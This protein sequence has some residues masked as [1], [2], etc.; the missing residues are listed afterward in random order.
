MNKSSSS[1]FFTIVLFQRSIFISVMEMVIDNG[2]WSEVRHQLGWIEWLFNSVESHCRN[3]KSITEFE[4]LLLLE[5]LVGTWLIGTKRLRL[6]ESAMII[7]SSLIDKWWRNKGSHKLSWMLKSLVITNRLQMLISVSLRYFIAEWEELEY[8]F[9]IQK[10]LLL[11]KKEARRISLWSIMSLRKE[12]W[13][14]ASLMLMKMATL[15]YSFVVSGSLA[16]VSQLE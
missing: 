9:M 16:N 8:T 3:I 11:M 12:K 13:N 14:D 1:L 2:A 15:G 5:Y 4:S 10:S 6:K 7:R